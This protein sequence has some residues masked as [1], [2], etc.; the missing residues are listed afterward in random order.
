MVDSQSP[1][2]PHCLGDHRQGRGPLRFGEPPL[3]VDEE[4]L[5][6]GVDARILG[7]PGAQHLQPGGLEVRVQTEIA[8]SGLAHQQRLKLGRRHPGDG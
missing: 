3:M 6:D 1:T 8:G 5:V 7:R 2:R 4:S